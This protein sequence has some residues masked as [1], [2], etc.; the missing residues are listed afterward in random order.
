MTNA[1]VQARGPASSYNGFQW[2]EENLPYP[3]EVNILYDD[4][5]IYVA[6]RAYD[7]EPDKIQRFAGVRDEFAGDIMGINF[8]SYHDHR[9]G[10]EFDLTAYGQQIDLVLF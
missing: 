4:K 6:M 5:N 7:K 2:K 8:D 9:T 10:F 3:T 1:G